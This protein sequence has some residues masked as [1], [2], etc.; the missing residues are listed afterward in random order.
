MIAGEADAAKVLADL[1]DMRERL[2]AGK[3]R[4]GPWDTENGPGG[5]QDVELLASACALV[6]GCPDRDPEVQ[7]RSG[8]VAPEVAEEL[9]GH[10]RFF[11]VLKQA[12][13]LLTGGRPDPAHLG[14]GGRDMLLRDTGTPDIGSLEAHIA[15]VL[16]HSAKIVDA[17]VQSCQD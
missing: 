10:L 11:G 17:A 7:L 1:Q 3:P 15:E 2:R 12:G 8:F 16:A 6:T 14:Q 4:K 9:I 5:R 13:R